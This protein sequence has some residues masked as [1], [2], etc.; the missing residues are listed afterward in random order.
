MTDWL[1]EAARKGM[2]PSPYDGKGFVPVEQA[3]SS[4]DTVTQFYKNATYSKTTNPTEIIN[5]AVFPAPL[6]LPDYLG[7][8]IPGC[9]WSEDRNL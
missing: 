1:I 4:E 8:A 7:C 2:K 9:D 3:L 6:E 5:S